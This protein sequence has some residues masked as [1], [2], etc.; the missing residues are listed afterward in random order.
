MQEYI[1][2]PKTGFSVF[3]LGL[4]TNRAGIRWDGEKACELFDCFL[5]RGGNLIDTARVYSDWIPGEI[6]RSER[7]IGEWLQ[8]SGKRNRVILSTKG[9][10][11][12]CTGQLTDRQVPRMTEKDMRYDLELSLR[13]L[14]TDVIDLYFYHRDNEK[15]SIEETVEIMEAFRRE[16]KIRYYGCSNWCVDRMRKAD[17]YCAEKGYTGFVADQALFNLGSRYMKSAQDDT[18]TCIKD[19]LQVYHEQHPENLAMP[20]KSVADG[21]SI[22]IYK[23]ERRQ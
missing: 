19:E 8:K 12:K 6:G 5:D 17:V 15:Q 4:G 18:L 16:G 10:H 23:V 2:I 3:P 9:G 7:V 1:H 11:P 21:F 14:H 13:S 20:Y 22:T